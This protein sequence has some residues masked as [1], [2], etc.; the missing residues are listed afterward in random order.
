M[1]VG[2]SV[3]LSLFSCTDAVFDFRAALATIACTATNTHHETLQARWR[4]LVRPS[5]SSRA[6]PTPGSGA[7]RRAVRSATWMARCQTCKRP[8]TCCR[9]GG[10][11]VAWAAAAAVGAG[12]LFG[13]PA[14]L[15]I[16]CPCQAPIRPHNNP[17]MHMLAGHVGRARR[18]LRGEGHAVPEAARLPAGVQGAAGG[19]QAGPHQ[20]PGV[21]CAGPVQVRV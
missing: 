18:V 11:W 12:G 5:R 20:P 17:V 16:S 14:T 7:A 2:A 13:L 3:F 9:C 4:T 21:E 1:R 15:S 8:S 19:C 10:R 6:T